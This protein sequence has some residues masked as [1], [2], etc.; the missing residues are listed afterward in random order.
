M[1]APDHKRR[2]RER[3]ALDPHAQTFAFVMRWGLLALVLG[4]LV[5]SIIWAIAV[6][7]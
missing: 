3:A 7:L 2:E 6:V 1:T 4:A 5:V